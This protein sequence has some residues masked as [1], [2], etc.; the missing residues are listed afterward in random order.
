MPTTDRVTIIVDDNAVYTDLAVY[1]NL[2]LSACGI[3]SNV[4]ALQF[5]NGTGHIELREPVP[6]I[7][8]TELP[9]WANNCLL[10]WDEAHAANPSEPL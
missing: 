10:K 4:H 9:E 7:A 6:N 2:D 1:I 8:I 5:K 3:P